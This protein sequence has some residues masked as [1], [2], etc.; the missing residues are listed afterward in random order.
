[1]SRAPQFTLIW[2]NKQQRYELRNSEKLERAFLPGDEKPFALWLEGHS[3]F[4]FIGQTGRLTVLKEARER[5]T[6]YWYAYRKQEQR[7]HKS[8]LGPSSRVS[9]A[10]L[11]EQARK[12]AGKPSPQRNS[13]TKDSTQ[14]QGGVLLSTKLAPPRL[15][16]FLV[17][18]PRL[19]A[20]LDATWDHPVSL[21]SASAGSGKTTLLTVWAAGASR[22]GDESQKERVVC[23]LSL[24]ELDN[25]AIRFWDAV[26]AALHRWLPQIGDA[27]LALLHARQS[28]PLSTVLAALLNGIELLNQ[29]VV[30]ILDDYHVIADQSIHEGLLFL[31]HHLPANLHLVLTSRIDP[32]LPLSRF[33]VRG[34]MREIR[35][36]EL[37]FTPQEA[38][39][40]FLESMG[41]TL[42]PEEMAT[43]HQR[44]E[45]WIAGLHLAA[46]AL[47]RREDRAA[48]VK[49]F[50]GSHRFVLEYVQQDI[51]A[52]LSPPL[53]DFVLQNAILTRM[54][55]PLCQAVNALPNIAMCQEML[56]E[57][58]RANLF[59]VPLD[60][61]R[62][63]YRFH[64]LFREALLARLHATRPELISLLHARAASFYETRG[65]WQEAIT[66][67]EAASDY[68]LAASLM[69][70]AAP[71]F[72]LSG[73][74]RIVQHWLISLP[75]AVFLKH[76]RLALDA[77]LRFLNSVHISSETVHASMAPLVERTIARVE[78]VLH[79]PADTS[80]SDAERAVIE[81]RLSVL[82]A[83]LETRTIIQRGDR[84]RMR[85]LTRQIDS[86]P[87]D[88]E[89][90]W[91]LIRL[92]FPYW[93]TVMLQGEEESLIPRLLEAKRQS[94]TSKDYLTAA[95]VKS[96]LARIYLRTG[97]LHQTHE[98]CV[99]ALALLEQSGG[100]TSMEGFLLSSLFETFY[101]WNRLKE[102]SQA[103][104]RFQQ[105]AHDWQQVELLVLG[106]QAQ[107]RLE[108]AR[109]KLSEAST[110]L[111]H[112][113][114]LVKEE[115]F[116]HHVPWVSALRV[117]L[118]L[119]ESKLEQAS[120]WTEQT[121]FATGEWNPLRKEEFL[122]YIEVLLAQQKAEQAIYLLTRWSHYLDQQND[123][124]TMHHFLALSVAS[125]YLAGRHGEMR[126]IAARLLVL[127][128]PE[129]SIRVYLDTGLL[130]KQALSTLL[131]IPQ[132]QETV[133]ALPRTSILRL[134][135]AFE[136][137]EADLPSLS[138]TINASAE[139]HHLPPEIS[140]AP[141]RLVESLTRREREVLHLLAAG[142]SNQEIAGELVI[143]LSTV[144]KHVSNL[145][146]KLGAESRTQAIAQARALSL[147]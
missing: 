147:F 132:D 71:H 82:Q 9:F 37:R 133:L 25:D 146:L 11:E 124:R 79:A 129:G 34:Q 53:Q 84:E 40:F 106:A 89:A 136:Q 137:A 93:L 98:E 70:R 64:D 142:A 122:A 135:M 75:D 138:S 12:L 18:R 68:G 28:P 57:M 10:R 100:R 16:G 67:A 102:A 46:L 99:Q 51:F 73:N 126:H 50:T 30:L 54:C 97:Q 38:T 61:H 117:H 59:V 81:P 123:I 76:T 8:Y 20:D 121:V 103:L 125:L 43:L 66:H 111:Q 96:R 114:V 19:L 4:A 52:H 1:M 56:E 60:E 23:W 113:E 143:E 88:A 22:P 101:A 80:P 32:A 139:A 107:V 29:E 72:W 130:M 115:G 128:E 49:A 131:S 95:Q 47:A 94:L 87:P 145:L 116:A 90:R 33:R 92:S 119:A 27:A 91:N 134:L 5:G 2:S 109:G 24:D 31:L 127:T 83:L 108:L 35:D 65:E 141:A 15:L 104:Q 21:V 17:E 86:L 45:G 26:I 7:T 13:E 69:E 110:A 42:S 74:S 120:S 144:K 77:A 44:T 41:L 63:W 14:T 58:E 105:L 3:S 78:S 140:A 55:A 118:W 112:M 6:G 36:R 85:A 48:F 39:D 62:Q